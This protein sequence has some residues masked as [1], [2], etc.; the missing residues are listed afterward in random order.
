MSPLSQPLDLLVVAPHPDD[1]EIS[2]GGTILKCISQGKQVGVV[3]LT[4]GEP[5]P[6]GTVELR[7]KETE[8]ATKLLGLHWRHQ[9]NLP[10]RR[11]EHTLEGRRALAE[12]FRLTRPRIILAPYWEDS[13][14]DHVSA[15][16]MVDA[17]RFWSKLSRTDMAGEPYYPPKIFYYWSIHLR[18]HPKPAFVMDISEFIDQKMQ[19]V[20]CYESQM[21]TGRSTAH[22][23]VMDDIRDRARFWGWSIERSYA[24]PFASREEIRVDDISALV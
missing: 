18:I 2:V 8:R 16:A 9:L 14:P 1:A 24:E 15:S 19:A 3:E 10:N 6:H 7:K 23:T 22:P 5:T 17:A 12:V 13:H 20:A 11:L 4:N 21:L